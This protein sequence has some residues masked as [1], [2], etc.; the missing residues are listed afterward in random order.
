[1]KYRPVH[2]VRNSVQA[3][4]LVGFLWAAGKLSY[5]AGAENAALQWL[6]RLD[7]WLLFSQVRWQHQ[8]PVWGW[9][10]LLTLAATALFGRFFCGW[11]CPFGALLA[12][13][14]HLSKKITGQTALFRAAVLRRCQPLIHA[15]LLLLFV[16]FALGSNWILFLTPFA[17][18]SHE[19][20]RL[21]QGQVPWLLAAILV[22]TALF[23]RLWCSV[24]CPTGLLLSQVARL[25]FFSYRVSGNCLQCGRCTAVCP[26]GCDPA[27]GGQ[28]GEGCLTCG[29]CRSA[30][31]TQAIAWGK[32]RSGVIA[33][34][35]DA[36]AAD[37]SVSRRRFFKTA[38]LLAAAAAFWRQTVWAAEKVLRP[39]G[40]LSEADFTAVCNRCG[41]C[42]KVCPNQALVPAPITQG[43]ANFATP[44]LI[45][46]QKRCDLCLACQEVCPTGA[47]ATVALE[48]VR[49]GQAVLDK[50]RCIA[51]EEHK[52]CLICAEQC[53]VLAIESDE[54]HRPVLRSEKCAGCGTC[55]NACPVDGEAAIRV[56]PR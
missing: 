53:P 3:I 56:I 14:D 26:V 34:L 33:E 11:L 49:M 54:Q 7:P 30:C 40:A 52:L 51:W 25:R 8:F 55:E 6:S 20:L 16:V 50:R 27:A 21:F 45:P 18:F 42:V 4:F 35:G 12:L 29:N 44:Y 39:P 23:S 9:L 1:M 32:A 28:A 5:P 46:R 17:L 37:G 43:F 22:G 13:T 31:P 41:R 10:P 47:I 15:W 19:T 38:F 48:Q 24:F 36:A 2:F